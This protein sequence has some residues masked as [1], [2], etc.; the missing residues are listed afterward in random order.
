MN[1]DTPQISEEMLVAY[2]DGELDEISLR[3]VERRLAEDDALA[4]RLAAHR[5]V[6]ASLD[7]EFGSLAQEQVPER[8]R[9]LL[10]ES[11]RTVSIAPPPVAA[12]RPQRWV[13]FAL[14]AS[15]A[16]GLLVGHGL[17]ADD[18][19]IRVQ[20]AHMIAQGALAKALDTQ[21]ASAQP[22]DAETRI[23]LSF[24]RKDGN[25][26]R[27]FTG[28]ALAGV[29]CR[30]GSQWRLEQVLPGQREEGAYRQA[31]SGDPRIVA[32]VEELMADAPADAAAEMRARDS[33]WQ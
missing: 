30:S 16:L 11:V 33:D 21:L 14:A 6:A 10:E 27:S 17:H 25:W 8:F 19:P 3:R 15:L 5:R 12:P 1:G 7:R 20:G 29:A 23:G 31:S 13:P 24:R 26:C 28:G 2:A 22:A 4:A 18:A 9:M 32:T